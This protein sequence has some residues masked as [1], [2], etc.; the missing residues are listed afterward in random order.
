MRGAT[1]REFEAVKPPRTARSHGP[2]RRSR[3]TARDSL[4]FER[5]E[6]SRDVVRTLR[7]LTASGKSSI[8][9]TD[10]RR[11][12]SFEPRASV[13][14][15]PAVSSRGVAARAGRGTTG[16]SWLA[17]PGERRSPELAAHSAANVRVRRERLALSV[18]QESVNRPAETGSSVSAYLNTARLTVTTVR[19]FG[20][21]S[22]ARRRAVVPAKGHGDQYDGFGTTGR[23]TGVADR[24]TY[25]PVVGA[26]AGRRPP[27][28]ESK[29]F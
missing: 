20:I 7:V 12:A 13:A 8:S 11:V 5:A 22:T 21:A 2:R 19:Y 4:S 23:S 15:L 24:P 29:L 9:R 14:L 28:I 17:S 16:P 26:P 27:A 1:R 18:R 3:L 10:E 25:S 6:L